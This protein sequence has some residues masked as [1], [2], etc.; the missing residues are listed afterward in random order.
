MVTEAKKEQEANK[1]STLDQLYKEVEDY[2]SPESKAKRKRKKI[3]QEIGDI[4]FALIIS[5]LCFFIVVVNLAKENNRVPFLF[6]YSIEYIQTGSM[7]PTLPIGSVILSKKVDASTEISVGYKDSAS[8]GDI[9]TFY[10]ADDVIVTHRAVETY[11]EGQV[12]YYKTK[13]DNN[14][15]LDP[16]PIP[17]SDVISLFIRRI[18]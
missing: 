14:N 13:G 5:L 3:Y 9:I 2:N 12:I 18:V 17:R 7:N 8:E 6:N 10:N 11:T 1:P 16:T 15:S 4:V